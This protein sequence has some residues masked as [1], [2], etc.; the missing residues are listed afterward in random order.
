[1]NYFD[2]LESYRKIK[3][4][5]IIYLFFFCQTPKLL[6]NYF[7]SKIAIN[8][9]NC[10]LNIKDFSV[11]EIT[12]NIGEENEIL[13]EYF[14]EINEKIFKNIQIINFKITEVLDNINIIEN[15]FNNFFKKSEFLKKSNIKKYIFHY[16]LEN[17]LYKEKEAL[18]FFLQNFVKKY[19]NEIFLNNKTNNILEMEVN[20]QYNM[21]ETEIMKKFFS[22]DFEGKLKIL[23]EI[24]FLSLIDENEYNKIKFIVKEAIIFQENNNI[25]KK[26][27]IDL[28]NFFS[29]K[30]KIEKYFDKLNLKNINLKEFFKKIEEDYK[31]HEKEFEINNEKIQDL[32]KNNEKFKFKK[33]SI[34][35]LKNFLKNINEEIKKQ[36]L[37][38]KYTCISKEI[39]IADAILIKLKHEISILEMEISFI[40]NEC[41][42]LNKNFIKELI[43]MREKH[44]EYINDIFKKKIYN[45]TINFI[46][47]EYI[48]Y[49]TLIKNIFDE[50]MK[51]S[52]ENEEKKILKPFKDFSRRLENQY[53]KNEKLLCNTY[54][55]TDKF[56]N[57][58]IKCE[59]EFLKIN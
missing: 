31:K 57:L 7:P 23:D 36:A 43:E 55:T 48:S 16:K 51:I 8:F 11:N 14:H 49:R 42:P 15:Q 50:K 53:E 6:L 59:I 13:T 3:E 45:I 39:D 41:I 1:M 34:T 37:I 10:I 28:K 21:E 5:N 24:R 4:I 27:K 30:I 20:F 32:M 47:K 19:I 52:F 12:I 22:V 46:L 26:N 29:E 17:N 9:L 56:P 44:S 58:N 2:K 25:L 40:N 33:E 54:I 35:Y 38:K 18:E